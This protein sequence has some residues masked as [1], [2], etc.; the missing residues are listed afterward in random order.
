MC[1]EAISHISWRLL[2]FVHNDTYF[3]SY[4]LFEQRIFHFVDL[5]KVTA[6]GVLTF[7]EI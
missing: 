7:P 3:M 1:A 5:L 4:F 2:H 6:E